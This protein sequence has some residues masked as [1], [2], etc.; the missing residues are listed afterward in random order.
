MYRYH[1]NL[2]NILVGLDDITLLVTVE[3]GRAPSPSSC[4]LPTTV[5]VGIH[6]Q[7]S[8]KVTSIFIVRDSMDPSKWH[9]PPV[10]SAK[11][12]YVEDIFYSRI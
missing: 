9:R 1:C 11:V 12:T 8:A 4:L 6:S 3:T 10:D 2:S 7:N 5:D